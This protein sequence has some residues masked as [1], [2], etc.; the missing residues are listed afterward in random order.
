MSDCVIK[1]FGK[2]IPLQPVGEEDREEEKASKIPNCTSHVSKLEDKAVQKDSEDSSEQSTPSQPEIP[3]SVSRNKDDEENNN[4]TSTENSKEGDDK[5]PLKKPDKILPCPRCHSMDT[6]F[7]YYN[8]Y[9]VNQ[10]RHFCKNC[11]RYWTAGGSMR[12]VPVGAGRRKSKSNPTSLAGSHFYRSLPV[13]NPLLQPLQSNSVN[14]KVNGTAT[15]LSFGSEPNPPINGFH[16][17]ENGDE[18]SSISSVDGS[19]C[20][21][22]E[23]KIDSRNTNTAINGASPWPYA[24]GPV[25]AVYNG[26]GFGVQ[27]YPYWGCIPL[28]NNGWTIPWTSGACAAPTNLG[29]HSRDGNTVNLEAGRVDKK[30]G[31]IWVPKTLRIDNPEEAAKSSIWTMVGIKNDKADKFEGKIANM[32][33]PKGAAKESSMLKKPHLLI[34]NPAALA[35]SVNFHESA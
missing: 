2:R 34:A 3:E 24:W 10:P 32:F 25:P 23:K 7:C 20:K 26:S 11:Q 8:N 30:D 33:E 17:L 22:E 31:N 14:S 1:L 16:I 29:K 13:P 5:V 12:N 21:D 28:N 35:R 9:N 18:N 27:I 4:N 15:V 6:K 19:K